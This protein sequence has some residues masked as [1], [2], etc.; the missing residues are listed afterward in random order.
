M[1]L[2]LQIVL[3][4]L[5]RRICRAAVGEDQSTSDSIVNIIMAMPRMVD[6]VLA[7]RLGAALQAHKLHRHAFMIEQ[8]DSLRVDERKLSFSVV[9]KASPN[10]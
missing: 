7:S 1:G 8:P 3:E 5:L 10:P 6:P 4:A 2:K 9:S